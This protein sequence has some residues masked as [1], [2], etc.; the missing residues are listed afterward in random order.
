MPHHTLDFKQTDKSDSAGRWE[1]LMDRAMQRAQRILEEIGPN[2]LNR[3]PG[4]VPVPKG[5]QLRD[6]FRM[7]QDPALVAQRHQEL[8]QQ[9]GPERGTRALVEWALDMKKLLQKT[10]GQ[11]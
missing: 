1:G 8:V 5:D 6:Y 4:S 7:T 11:R 2:V 10:D 9:L 3:P